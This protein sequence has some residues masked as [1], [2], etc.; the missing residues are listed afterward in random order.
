MRIWFNRGFSLAPIAAAMRDADPTLEVFVSVGQ[1]QPRYDG[2]SATLVEPEDS[3]AAYIDWVRETIA[4]NAIDI[5]IPTRRR[6][7]I[8]GAELDCRVEL[9][10]A[11]ATLDLLDDKFAFAAAIAG[12]AYHLETRLITSSAALEQAIA[13]FR[14]TGPAGAKP[15]V[16][17]RKGVNGHGFWRLTQDR[18]MSHLDNPDSRRITETLY[19]A[20]AAAAEKA[21]AL[22]DLVLME[23]LPGPEVS[24]DMLADKGVLLKFAARTKLPGGVQHIQTDHFLAPA[25]A[26][27]VERFA[28][29]GVVNAQFRRA[30]DGSWKLLEINSR[31]AGGILY[32][33]QVGCGLLADWSA[34]LTGRKHAAQVSRPSIDTQIRLTTIAAQIA[35]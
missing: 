14:E 24:F 2:P 13:T 16:K 8:A 10:A 15:C 20:A 32:S 11:I 21:G 18:P 31:P 17:P 25:A 29:H 35:A 1:N 28:L 30:A 19:I 22:E 12:T 4:A 34:L 26:A 23:Y 9:P 7:L 3:E 33:E 6:S 27:L 5:F